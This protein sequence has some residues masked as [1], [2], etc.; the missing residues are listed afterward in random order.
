[1][2]KA[3]FYARVSSR[4]QVEEEVSLPAQLAGGER[5]ATALGAKVVRSFVDEGRSA[6]KESNRPEFEA[7][8]E[9]ATLHEVD[10]FITW[11]SARFAR[12]K[13]E[14]HK[15][16]RDLERAG[17]RLE[18]VS[19]KID[20]ATDEGWL[21][22]S[23][24]E[25]FD[26]WRSRD[27]SKDTRRSLL[28]NARQG[29]YCGGPPPFGFRSV[30]A[31]DNPK[32]RKLV[33]F[34]EEAVRVR[35]VFDLRKA[36]VG[37]TSIA[38]RYNALGVRYRGK[39][40]RQKTVLELL[41]NPAVIGQTIFNRKDPRTKRPRPAAEWIVLQTHEPIIDVAT[42]H[43]VQAMIDAIAETK[44]ARGYAASTHPFTGLLRCGTCGGTLTVE[45]ASGNGG[46]YSYYGCHRGKSDG[47]CVVGRIPAP[48]L[49]EFLTSVIFD[50]LLD[51]AALQTMATDLV[52][53]CDSWHAEHRARRQ[54]LAG[55]LQ[56]VQSRN[57]KL[58]EVLEELGRDAPNLGDLAARL[59]TNNAEV[60]ALEQQIAELDDEQPPVVGLEG[61]DLDELGAEIRSL[62]TESA[63]IDRLR[64]FYRSIIRGITIRDGLAEIEYYP[65]QVISV[66]APV[67]RNQIW[68]GTGGSLR[69]RVLQ[70]PLSAFV[71]ARGA[72]RRRVGGASPVAVIRR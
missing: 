19:V 5:H 40:W 23:F 31:P 20:L 16:K 18:Y 63:S 2:K 66:P 6:F 69:T 11:S 28:H 15:F 52:E 61:I 60:K 14:A 25:V 71:M 33:P 64:A 72:A 9:Y 34:D 7:A 35:E 51:R 30:P 68:G 54:G 57:V 10:Y 48:P 65:E 36:G 43:E 13:F 4:Q 70:V 58:Y 67:H 47:T 27:T 62:F 41:R 56:R 17:V 1:M 26:E 21:H 29:Y 37:G 46:R 49:D 45:T 59:R 55:Q 22:D 39:A 3:V 50:R 53:S 38:S 42:W 12:N 8:I 44:E 32:R 24:M